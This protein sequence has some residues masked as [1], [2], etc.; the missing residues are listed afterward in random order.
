[1]KL[2]D[3]LTTGGGII[4]II[5]FFKYLIDNYKE[6]RKA[7][8]A[9]KNKDEI[10]LQRLVKVFEDTTKINEILN[11]ITNS[12]HFSRV[13]IFR[14]NNGGNEIDVLSQMYISVI[15]ESYD[16]PVKSVK[17]TYQD[18]QVDN[19]YLKLLS[20]CF[21]SELNAFEVSKLDDSIIKDNYRKE[22]VKRGNVYFLSKDDK[23]YHYYFLSGVSQENK[24]MSAEESRY[25]KHKINQLKRRINHDIN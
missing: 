17:S 10:M 15:H 24:E 5:G 6:Y 18:F 2:L 3:W 25:M 14:L 23:N 1:M 13:T 19:A 8:L 12:T 11:E 4:A 9:A 16:K 21:N 20:K 7:K 22:G